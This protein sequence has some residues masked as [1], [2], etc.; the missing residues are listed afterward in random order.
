MVGLGGGGDEV[1]SGDEFDEF[2][3]GKDGSFLCLAEDEGGFLVAV[4]EDEG[5]EFGVEAAFEEVGIGAGFVAEDDFG[6]RDGA[7]GG[8]E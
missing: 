2:L 7:V 1:F 6:D 5:G 4:F 3:A 8:G